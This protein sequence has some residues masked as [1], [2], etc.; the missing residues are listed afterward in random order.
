VSKNNAW[1]GGL[2]SCQFQPVDI[3]LNGNI[4]LLVFDRHGNRVLPFINKGS[5]YEFSPEYIHLFPDL[6]DWVI[7]VD[8]NRDGKQDIFTYSLG[9]ARVFE[10]ISDTSLKFRLVTNLL[11]SFYFS[12]Y[13][14]ILITSVDYPAISDIDVDGDMDLL[15]FFGLGSFIEYHRN[16]SIEKYGIPDSLDYRLEESCWGNFKESEGSNNI[17]LNAVCPVKDELYLPY[18]LKIESSPKHTGSTLLATDLNGDSLKDLILGDVDF[19]NLIALFNNGT[20]D[21]ANMSS[22]DTLFPFYSL[23][24]NLFS[25]PAASLADVD[26][27][28]IND[29]LISPFDPA[30]YIA[31]NAKSCWFYKNTGTNE[32][33]DFQFVTSQFLQDQMIDAGTASLPSLADI[34]RDGI[35]DLLIG[36]FGYYDSSEYKLGILHSY[37]N[38]KIGVYR[39]DGNLF[40]PSFSFLTDDLAGLSSLHLTGLAPT[41]ADLDSDGDMDLI[42][43]N[44]EGNLIYLENKSVSPGQISFGTPILQYQGID[45]GNFSTPQL[46]DIDKDGLTDLVIGEQNGNLNYFRNIGTAGFPQFTLINDSLGRVNVTNPSISYNG[47]STPCFLRTNEGKT[48]LVCGSEEGIIHLYTDIDG[49]LSGKFREVDSLP[50]ILGIDSSKYYRVGW[51]SAPAISFLSDTLWPDLIV[52]N[53]S[54]G[55]NFFSHHPLPQVLLGISPKEIGQLNHLVV[56]PNPANDYIRI[57][58]NTGKYPDVFSYTIYDIT[59]KKVLRGSICRDGAISTLNLHPGLYTVLIFTKNLYSSAYKGSVKVMIAR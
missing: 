22:M 24:V 21:S 27:D 39:N 54:G 1:T 10:N 56:F 40:S 31:E 25:F 4:D 33:P 42:V 29:L 13:I 20:L 41:S 36:N 55:L 35:K 16:M 53:F 57:R 17:T 3:D 11:K 5:Y 51:R 59:G 7:C 26:N 23:P 30:Y 8:Y 52:G 43:G 47:F 37:Y 48:W 28:S 15:T 32:V 12:S 50:G 34:D 58:Y 9:G 38:S 6:H 49:N 46:F 44:S 45:V 14:G 2:N 19:P 18:A